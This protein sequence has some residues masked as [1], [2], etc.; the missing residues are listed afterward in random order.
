LRF[1]LDVYT[2]PISPARCASSGP[3]AGKR[4]VKITRADEI[5]LAAARQILL[6][7]KQASAAAKHAENGEAGT[8]R[9]GFIP[10]ASFYIVPQFLEKLRKTLPLV[11]VELR[12][13]PETTLIL[14]IQSGAFDISIGHLGED[15]DQ[16]ESALLLREPVVVALPKGHKA[17]RKRA[18]GL[19]DL[20]GDLFIIPSKD[21]LP[22]L[23]QMIVT[24]FLQHH[25]SLNRYQMVEHFQTAVALTKARGGVAF[26]PS[27]AKAFVPECVVLRPTNCS[28]RPLQTFAFWSR[29]N[30]DLLIHRVL[31]LLK[32]VSGHL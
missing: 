24:V 21:V 16:I 30:V 6:T 19:R 12:E 3:C 22:S 5:F 23:H 26:L 32:E 11:N 2:Q 9:L 13:G 8:I 27:S 25:V 4:G 18:V 20:E 15:Y 29:G 1:T 28:I 10:T 14:G 31:N 17:A 7:L